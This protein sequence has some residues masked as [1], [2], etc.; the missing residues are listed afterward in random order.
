MSVAYLRTKSQIP[1]ADG[2]PVTPL[3]K[4]KKEN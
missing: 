2:S 1:S 3:K 4:L